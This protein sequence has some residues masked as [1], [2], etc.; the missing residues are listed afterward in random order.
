MPSSAPSKKYILRAAKPGETPVC[1]FFLSA[2][3][4]R[5]GDNCK[6]LHGKPQSEQKERSCPSV[7]K[8]I[9]DTASVIS[10]ESESG[11]HA[12]AKVA[13]KKDLPPSTNE[14]NDMFS[15]NP[16][17]QSEK[18]NKKKKNRR[19]EDNDI[20][21]APKSRTTSA[22]TKSGTEADQP[23]KKKRKKDDAVKKEE[24]TTPAPLAA[25]TS[26]NNSASTDFR[27]MLSNMP[28]KA[29][30]IP[31]S[32]PGPKPSDAATAS[33]S[34][35]AAVKPVKKE[36]PVPTSTNEN[37]ALP[38]DTDAGKKWKKACMK[39][40]KH[41]RFQGTFDFDKIKELEQSNNIPGE[42][43]RAKPYGAWCKSNP[44]AIAIDC[45]MCE[46]TDPVTK[47]KN[48]KALCRIS[49]V[50]AEKP[51]EV[52]LDTLVKPQWPVSDYRTRINGINEESLK[53]VEFTLKHAQDFMMALCS[54][55]TVIV[56]QA[57]INDLAAMRMEHYCVADSAFLFQ[58]KD[59]PT[60]SV[61]LKDLVKFI[62]KVDMPNT[63]DSV[64]DARKALECIQYW[65]EKDGKVDPIERTTNTYAKQLFLHRLPKKCTS[66]H[67]VTMFLKHT[68][69]EPSEVEDI[70]FGGGSFGKTH[71]TFRSSRH[72]VL[73]FETLES[74]AEEEAS[75]RLQKKVFL[76]DGSYI[77]VR[78][79]AY[80]KRKSFGG[81]NGNTLVK[82]ETTPSK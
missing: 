6:F 20:F 43:I 40:Y 75:G 17:P 67:L 36:E 26:N 80:Q 57:V 68:S 69:I 65:I 78:Q 35:K 81:G 72:A 59:S 31:G 74:K 3:G 28:V 73:A 33:L 58:A 55:K 18:K 15:P 63:H 39:T 71:V 9:S 53:D 82:T 44:I 54:E 46:T 66:E 52:L 24:A 10:S 4:C 8:E 25:A 48:P 41:D 62:F 30:F 61:S 77:R 70:E 22:V 23:A 76:R 19:S 60:S 1:A 47:S 42:W 2:D 32:T 56:G 34:Q 51:D 14:D 13:V 27:R 7:P 16:P 38:P 21:A 45:E 79:M 29:F 5:N 49:I 12:P 50:N 64:N 37:P 11:A